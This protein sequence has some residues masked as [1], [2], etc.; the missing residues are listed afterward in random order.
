MMEGQPLPEMVTVGEIF[1]Q[2]DLS[3]ILVGSLTTSV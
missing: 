2:V 3:W 1:T